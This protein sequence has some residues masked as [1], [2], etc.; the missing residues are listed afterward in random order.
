MADAFSAVLEHWTPEPGEMASVMADKLRFHTD[1]W[2]L[3]VDLQ[4]G[5]PMVIVI[6]ARSRDAYR[7][8]HIPGALSLPHREMTTGTTVQ[9]RR[10]QGL[11]RLLRRDR[12]Q[13]VDRGCL[14]ALRSR[15]P[16]QGTARWT[17]LVASRRTSGRDV[18]CAR[19]PACFGR[20]VGHSSSS[21]HCARPVRAVAA[22]LPRWCRKH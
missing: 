20:R 2:D 4:A 15:L 18:R 9:A 3:S 17:G 12:L 5:H 14:Q 21:R 1:A 7:A 19:Q 13:C 22:S 8:G 16:H 6:D 10:Q 11:R